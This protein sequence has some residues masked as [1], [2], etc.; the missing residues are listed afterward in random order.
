V[1]KDHD[2]SVGDQ[3]VRG[4]DGLLAIAIVVGR[5]HLDLLAQHAASGVEV[6][7]GEFGALLRYRARP[8]VQSTAPRGRSA[9]RRGPAN[10]R[11][12]RQN[13]RRRNKKLHK[14]HHDLPQ[15]EARTGFTR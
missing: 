4:G 11:R 9:P 12:H 10:R 7:N 8:W 13:G 5:D 15:V 3:L 14:S 6:G 2:H 1:T